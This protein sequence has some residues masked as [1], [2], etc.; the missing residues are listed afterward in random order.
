MQHKIDYSVS[1]LQ[2]AE[3]I[4]LAYC[5]D[6]FRLAFSGIGGFD[7]AAVRFFAKTFFAPL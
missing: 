2:K 7:L 4:A 1:L 5:P 6:G 3:K